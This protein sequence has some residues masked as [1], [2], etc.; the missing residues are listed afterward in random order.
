MVRVGVSRLQVATDTIATLSREGGVPSVVPTVQYVTV[1]EEVDP[2]SIVRSRP[3]DEVV[4]LSEEPNT[5]AWRPGMMAF[6]S[7]LWEWRSVPIPFRSKVLQKWFLPDGQVIG[8]WYWK[9]KGSM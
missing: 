1:E 8:S 6:D 5:D 2:E 3:A 7:Y 9:D 4:E